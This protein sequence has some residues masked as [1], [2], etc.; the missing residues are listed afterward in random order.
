[1]GTRSWIARS[2]VGVVALLALLMQFAA[3]A[4]RADHE[5]GFYSQPT[6]TQWDRMVFDVLIVPPNHGQIFNFDTDIL[7]GGDV[8]ELTPN[9]T[10][11]AAMERAVAAWDEAVAL[12]GSGQLR[13]RFVTNV[14]VVGRDSIPTGALSDPEILIVSD[15]NQAFSLGTTYRAP[16][17]VSRMSKFS[18]VSFTYADMYNVTLHEYGH[19]LGLG[20]MG[21]QGGVDP[22]AEQ[23]HPEHDVMNGFYGDSVGFEGTHLHCISN[24]NVWGLEWVLRNPA[25]EHPIA[26]RKSGRVEMAVP[27]YGS[28]CQPPQQQPPPYPDEEP[29]P[30]PQVNYY[31]RDI[32]FSVRAH[33]RAIGRVKVYEAKEACVSEIGVE[34]VRKADG[35]WVPVKTGVTDTQGDFRIRI[36]DRRGVYAARVADLELNELEVCRAATSP[37]VRHRHQGRS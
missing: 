11:L 19:C 21:D 29:P 24:L 33:L 8:N 2:R 5:D 17:C 28:T 9:N 10:Y 16:V 1:M 25:G 23:K 26:G 31:D 30:P 32:E 36:P 37:A 7:G 12:F 22:L 14:Y 13:S 3:G 4:A 6:H 20:H 34:I 35:E 27:H 15:E 18:I